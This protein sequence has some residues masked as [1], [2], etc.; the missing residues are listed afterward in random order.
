MKS[1]G[2]DK[3]IDYTKEDF[4]KTGETYDIIFDIIGKSTFSNFS[5]SLNE[6]GIYLLAN[7]NLSL[8]NREKRIAKKNVIK[9]ISGNRDTE[10]QMIEGLIFLKELIE[11]GKIK[12][13]I[14]RRYS[15]EQVPEAHQYV[16]KGE[17]TGNVVINLIS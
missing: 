11:D 8:I 12:T 15:L 5:N 3:V 17:K 2:A 13:V 1:L 7:P 4:T 9:Y 10:E 16:E 14:D 6:N